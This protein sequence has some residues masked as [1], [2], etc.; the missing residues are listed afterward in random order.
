MDIEP[1]CRCGSP[2]RYQRRRIAS[3]S[4]KGKTVNILSNILIVVAIVGAIV[5]LIAIDRKRM[6]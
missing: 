1:A 3:E 6:L 5:A 2:G 4:A